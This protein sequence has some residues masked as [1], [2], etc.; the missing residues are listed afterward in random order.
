MSDSDLFEKIAPLAESFSRLHEEQI[1]RLTP[2]VDDLIR[3]RVTDYRRIERLVDLVLDSACTD[4][5]LALYKRLL[6]YYYTIDP[7]A[8]A[9]YVV[10]YREMWE[11]DEDDSDWAD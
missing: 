8:T 11:P 2:L 5:G 6:R 7:A 10:I 3:G 4:S 1:A 9:E